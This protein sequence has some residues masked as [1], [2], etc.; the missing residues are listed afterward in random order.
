MVTNANGDLKKAFSP[1]TA[2]VIADVEARVAALM[3]R[4]GSVA[5]TQNIDRIMRLPGTINLPNKKKLKAGRTACPTKLIKFTGETCTLGDFPSPKRNDDHAEAGENIGIDELPISG[6][7]KNLMRG[8]DDPEHPYASRSE[9]VF[10][11]ILAM[12]SAGCSDYQIAAVMLDLNYPISAHVQ[13]QA[14]PQE[15]LARQI[16]NARKKTTDP[17]VAKVNESYALVIVGDKTAV[18]KTVGNGISFLTVSAFDQWHANKHV[19]RND[20]KILLGKYWIAHSQRRQYEGITFDPS[21]REVPNQFNL[22]RGFSVEPKL[23]DC[24]KFLAHV[25]ENICR[26]DDSLYQ[27]VLGWLAD[28]VR[29]P[30]KKIGTS[31]VLR[32]AQGVGKTKLGEVFG[33]LLGPHYSLVSD[34]RYV[35]GR[36]NSH[37]SS[38]LLLHC[39]ESFWAGDHAA[40]GRLKD[41]VTGDHHFIEFKGKEAI[42]VRNYVRLLVCGNQNWLVPAGFG[43]RRFATLDVGEEHKQDHAYFAA[44]DAEMESGGREAL[45][46]FLMHFDLKSVNLR[47]IPHTAALLEQ[48]LSSLD[49][50]QGWWLDMLARGELPWGCVGHHF[51][52]SKRLFDRYV[53]HAGRHGVR[54][55]AIETQLGMFLNKHV[56]GLRRHIRGQYSTWT[57]AGRMKDTTGTTYEFPSLTACRRAF[58]D[59]LE[60]D[61]IW[62]EKEE[63]T[64]EPSPDAEIDETVI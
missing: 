26:G 48:K 17:D 5:G 7:I 35:T 54:R 6:R 58:A 61:F 34:P 22:W 20:K 4:L 11:V 16:S 21:R 14:N 52:P 15:Y 53:T 19:I 60:Q 29:H 46:D 57:K 43:E 42:R 50:E 1:E 13:E 33:S 12:V 63:W 49:A 8:R 32:G 62:N 25:K 2:V 36:F 30:A 9:A 39:D 45:L 40:E 28:I 56:P 51:C 3:E 38:C 47:T 55:R 27:W 31:L 10:A 24:S 18:L 64:H 37:L 44:I 59:A 23:G 41:L